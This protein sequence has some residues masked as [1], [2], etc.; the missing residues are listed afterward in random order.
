[1]IEVHENERNKRCFEGGD[2]QANDGIYAIKS[3]LAKVEKL[4][5]GYSYGENCADKQHNTY[6]EVELDMFFD[7][8]RWVGHF[9]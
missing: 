7:R 3:P 4:E 1:M 9:E 8:F 2:E 5:L 6:E